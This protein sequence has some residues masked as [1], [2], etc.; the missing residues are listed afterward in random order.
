MLSL[1]DPRWNGLTGGYRTPYDPRAALKRL[2]SDGAS[3]EAWHELW[4]ELHH[5]GD[6]DEASYAAVPVLVGIHSET[7]GLD[8]NLY[9]L[10][11]TIEIERHRKTN[12]ALPDWVRTDYDQAW[13]DLVE[14]ALDDV[15]ASTDPLLLQSGLAV[16]AIGKGMLRLGALISDL[17]ESE[18]QEILE[19]KLAWSSIYDAG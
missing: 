18:L 3:Q 5:Q 16:V 12:P 19:S 9:A 4:N 7:H 8:W 13:P 17:D 10:S 1:E 11:A 15:R 14:A 2:R 6:V